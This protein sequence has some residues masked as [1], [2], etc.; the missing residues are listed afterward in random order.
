MLYSVQDTKVKMKDIGYDFVSIYLVLTVGSVIM[1][2][3]GLTECVPFKKDGKCK[4]RS[5]SSKKNRNINN[6]TTRSGAYSEEE[7]KTLVALMIQV[8]VLLMMSTSCYSFAGTLFKQ[9]A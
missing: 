6:W 5:L 1:R 3:F 8:A 9:E 7:K 2:K 4:A